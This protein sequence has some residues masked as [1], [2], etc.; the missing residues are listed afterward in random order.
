METLKQKKV[1]KKSQSGGV[2]LQKFILNDNS[3]TCW[4]VIYVEMK[5]LS[6]NP[7]KKTA[8][9]VSLWLI[10]SVTSQFSSEDSSCVFISFISLSLHCHYPCNCYLTFWSTHRGIQPVWKT[11][12]NKAVM[13]YLVTTEHRGWNF[14]RYCFTGSELVVAVTSN[15][16]ISSQGSAVL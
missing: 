8:A 12:Q 11:M 16:D 7:S 2:L 4:I 6:T 5:T 9:P 3:T 10:N 15:T 14:L 1:K 13:N